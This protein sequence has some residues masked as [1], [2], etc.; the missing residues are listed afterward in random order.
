MIANGP[1]NCEKRAN[2]CLRFSII[3]FTIEFRISGSVLDFSPISILAICMGSKSSVSLIAVENVTPFR[4]K[5]FM[6]E[7]FS[8]WA[9]ANY[10]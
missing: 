9:Y 4:S 10:E 2:L 7:I 3:S 6:F 8:L 1:I 5:V